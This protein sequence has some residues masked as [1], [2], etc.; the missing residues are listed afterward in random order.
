M[1]PTLLYESPVMKLRMRVRV[2]RDHR[3]VYVPVPVIM[4]S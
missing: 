3:D 1:R 2:K 4:Q